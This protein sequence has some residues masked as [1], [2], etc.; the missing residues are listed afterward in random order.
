MNTTTT[1]IDTL[2][3]NGQTLVNVWPWT[4]LPG[5]T[6]ILINGAL[7]NVTIEQLESIGTAIEQF[8]FDNRI[9]RATQSVLKLFDEMLSGSDAI[10]ADA[11]ERGPELNERG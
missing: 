3:H 1:T 6:K 11:I 5:G 8:L 7:S 4:N 2:E 10:A 9:D